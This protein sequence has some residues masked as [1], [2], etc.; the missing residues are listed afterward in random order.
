M[1][2]IQVEDRRE[3]CYASSRGDEDCESCLGEEEGADAADYDLM[4]GSASDV[5]VGSYRN[6]FLPS[7]VLEVVI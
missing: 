1:D 2:L 5:F 7:G 3:D 6:V 4:F